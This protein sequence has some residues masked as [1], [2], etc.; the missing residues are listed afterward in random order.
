[1]SS[2]PNRLTRPGKIIIISSPSGG[3]KTTIKDNLLKRHKADGWTFSVSWTTRPIRGGEKH[4]REYFF[5]DNRKFDQLRKAGSFAESCRVH[6]HQYG[7][8]RDKLERV[9]KSGGVILL[10]VDVKGAFKIK[11]AYPQA[12][13]IF[14]LPPSKAELKRRLKSRGTE[15]REQL[16]LRLEN[17][18]REMRLYRRFDY[19][20]INDDLRQATELVDCIIQSSHA[21]KRNLNT[22]RIERIIG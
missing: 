12:V 9:I 13:S 20:A 4:G 17:S 3:G 8:P 2:K 7:T 22:E 19:T 1:M 10:D 16:K 5:C 14:I 21:L 15:S 6:G 18:L 11:K